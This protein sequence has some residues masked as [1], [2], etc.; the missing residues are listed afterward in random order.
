MPLLSLFLLLLMHFFIVAKKPNLITYFCFQ[1]ALMFLFLI[2]LYLESSTRFTYCFRFN[3]FNVFV[4]MLLMHFFIVAKKAQPYY[5]CFQIALM[6]LFFIH[7]TSKL[8]CWRALSPV[9]C[10]ALLDFFTPLLRLKDLVLPQ[11]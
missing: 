2:F 1:I 6:F 3:A 4:F 8:T 11:H 10:S 7:L 9:K 5:F